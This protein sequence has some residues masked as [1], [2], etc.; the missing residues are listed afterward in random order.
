MVR[1]KEKLLSSTADVN[2]PKH[3]AK[4]RKARLVQMDNTR[5]ENE[6]TPLLK[7]R[8]PKK[9]KREKRPP[10]RGPPIE[11]MAYSIQQFCA[12]HGICADTYF[13]FARQVHARGHEGRCQNI[14]FS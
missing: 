14:D 3:E 7:Q 12:A 13:R 2:K 11:P 10:V 6:P 9:P 5:P 4:P 1:T 8:R